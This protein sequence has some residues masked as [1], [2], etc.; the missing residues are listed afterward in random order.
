M[1]YWVRS[2]EVKMISKQ[3]HLIINTIIG[4]RVNYLHIGNNIGWSNR[5][6]LLCLWRDPV[7]CFRLQDNPKTYHLWTRFES[8]I[9]HTKNSIFIFNTKSF[10]IIKQT[11]GAFNLIYEYFCGSI[12]HDP[13][14]LDVIA[15][16]KNWGLTDPNLPT[17]YH[18]WERLSD[19]SLVY[20]INK[21]L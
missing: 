18:S 10:G 13:I 4:S 1:N 3:S 15:D 7:I 19:L 6:S 2:A 21:H 12:F 16:K 14:N 8:F 5:F 9:S 17:N 11:L 20:E